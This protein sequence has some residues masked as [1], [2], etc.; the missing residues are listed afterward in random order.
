MLHCAWKKSL[1]QLDSLCITS[2]IVAKLFD[3][4]PRDVFHLLPLLRETEC[5][6]LPQARIEVLSVNPE[7]ER[8]V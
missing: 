8:R 6:A 3:C 1:R 5:V 4:S 2:E 7:K